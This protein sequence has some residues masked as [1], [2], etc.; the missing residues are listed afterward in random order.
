M[1]EHF[2]ARLARPRLQSVDA[3]GVCYQCYGFSHI[4]DKGVDMK[5]GIVA[6]TFALWWRGEGVWA[7]CE[8]GKEVGLDSLYFADHV[9]TTPKQASGQGDGFMDIWTAMAYVAAVTNVQGWHPTLGQ[10]AVVIPYRPPVQQAKIAAT[11]DSL[12]GG[13]L[14][15]G[16]GTGVVESEFGA[17]GL[18]IRERGDMTDEYLKCMIELW[19]HPVASFHGKYVNFDEMTISVRPVQ[20]P[21]PPILVVA[22]GPRP[23]RRI[24]EFCQGWLDGG[25][26]GPDGLRSVDEGWKEINALWKEHGR[27]GNPYLAIGPARFHLTTR[28]NQAGEAIVR[29]VNDG[30]QPYVSSFPLIHVDDLVT[31]IRSYADIG[32]NEV[33]LLLASYH[34]GEFDNQGMLANQLELLAEHVL[35]KIARW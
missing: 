34:F 16:A 12:S 14:L 30:P 31:M 25:G 7:T 6:P 2:R 35:P 21:H 26:R 1:T 11:V 8:K 28:R 4:F 3:V 22:K 20:Q 5:I 17:L 15:I 27:Q 10:C 23:F 19:T 13:R 18:N 9:I 32:V 29:G 24:A 33:A